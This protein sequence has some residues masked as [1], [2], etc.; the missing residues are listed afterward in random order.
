MTIETLSTQ[1]KAQVLAEAL[2]WLKQLHGRVVV[3]KYGGNAMTDDTLRQAFAADMAFLRNCGIHP[4]VVHGGGPQIT[5]MLG[6][7]GIEGDFKGGFRVTTPEV[8]DVARMVL[9][10]QV[11]RELVNLINA[12]GP[13]AVGVTGEDAQLFTAVRRSVNVDGV[14]TDIGLVGDVD[15]VNAAAL[16]DLIAAHR[17]PVIST[18]APD[19]EGVVHNI[20]A[21]TAA[22]AVAEALGAEK[23]LMLTDVEGL[24][25]S[26]PDRDSLVRE[27]DTAALEQLLP[28]L[29]AGMIPKVEGC[30][31]AVTGGVPSAH[32]IDGRVEHCVL[33]EL[34]TNAGTGTKVVSA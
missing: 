14:A 24:Y 2:R 15:H 16:M 6:K 4:V 31:R 22:A 1:S 32:V 9:F 3:I 20:N 18:L 17:I 10:G 11:G 5:A 13:Y 23:L 21:D 33:V 12:H 34:F 27:I 28:R 29:E 26:W 30:L 8:L 7:L 19:A 25:T